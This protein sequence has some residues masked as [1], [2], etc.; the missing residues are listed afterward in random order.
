MSD[1]RGGPEGVPDFFLDDDFV[2]GA[3]YREPSAQEREA[4]ASAEARAAKEAADARRKAQRQ[5]ERKEMLARRRPLISFA[6]LILLGVLFWLVTRSG[7][8]SAGAVGLKQVQAYYAV[9]AGA[10]GVPDPVAAI[11]AEIGVVQAWFKGETG[12]SL[13][14]V[15]ADGQL[16]VQTT[17]LTSG[18]D[19]LRLE[20]PEETLP[21]V[22]VPAEVAQPGC[23]EGSSP[24]LAVVL[25]GPCGE[26]PSTATR[27]FGQGSTFT[28]AHELVHALG[29]VKP[30][31][32][33]H[34]NDGHTRDDPTDLM[35]DGGD[36]SAVLREDIVLDPERDDYYET[37]KDG[38]DGI[39]KSRLWKK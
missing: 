16:V 39:D 19:A 2:A 20:A 23:G 22:F 11:R 31:A 10:E 32:P 37:G 25:V 17:E 34:G 7:G 5:E 38:C 6:V 26:T 4:V 12:R 27:A 9:P 8:D 29:A 18:V 15:E 30:C 14:F 13:R 33:H 24:G 21:L 35:Y 3:R 36:G 1:D 28:I